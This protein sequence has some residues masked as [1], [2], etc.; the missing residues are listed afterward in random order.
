MR[1]HFPL[2]KT[3]IF[4]SSAPFSRVNLMTWL[5]ADNWS[6]FITENRWKSE[7]EN[8]LREL[9]F[10]AETFHDALKWMTWHLAP[11]TVDKKMLFRKSPLMRV[12][13]SWWTSF[14]W[15]QALGD[16]S[17]FLC[18]FCSKT[19]NKSQ[20]QLHLYAVKHSLRHP[21]DINKVCGSDKYVIIFN[22]SIVL[23]YTQRR[24]VDDFHLVLVPRM[25]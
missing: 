1:Q 15:S 16:L 3:L 13:S 8:F 19:K 18:F 21:S 17:T 5:R 9:N 24:F 2:Q 20:S 11:E 22:L 7:E 12:R 25:S 14:L 23:R 4:S 10:V 6:L